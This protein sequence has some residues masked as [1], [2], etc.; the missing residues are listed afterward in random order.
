LPASGLVG[1]GT[2]I[3]SDLVAQRILSIITRSD[4]SEVPVGIVT[5]ILGAPI[6]MGLLRR[7]QP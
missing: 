7:E 2:L 5:A 1:A 3:A 6:L 4:A